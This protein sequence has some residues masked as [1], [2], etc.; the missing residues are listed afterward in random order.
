[1]VICIKVIEISSIVLQNKV[2]LG[3]LFMFWLR[4]FWK[5]LYHNFLSHFFRTKLTWNNKGDFIEVK[6]FVICTALLLPLKVNFYYFNI[7]IFMLLKLESESGIRN[8]E[9]GIRNPNPDCKKS[10]L[11]SGIRIRRFFGRIAIPV[12]N[13]N[14][15]NFFWF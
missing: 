12:K 3:L 6:C 5:N 14:G 1:M 9:S 4:Y 7:Q 2:N 15:F 8:P 13:I 10:A 11:E